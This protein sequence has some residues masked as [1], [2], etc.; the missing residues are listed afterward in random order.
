VDLVDAH[1]VALAH[2]G[3]EDVLAELLAFDDHLLADW[4]DLLVEGGQGVDAVC[5]FGDAGGDGAR[6]DA[7]KAG[8][9]HY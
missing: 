3:V 8:A 2:E 7:V 4:V 5:F 9:T 1:G 6:V